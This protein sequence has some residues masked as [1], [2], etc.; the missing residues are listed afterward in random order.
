MS[1]V[2]LK[3]IVSPPLSR[4]HHI[5]FAYFG[6]EVVNWDVVKEHV[7]K[8]KPFVLHFDSHDVFNNIQVAKYTTETTAENEIRENMLV[9]LGSGIV[10]Q[11]RMTWSPHVSYEMFYE[12][13][14][15]FRVLGVESND[16]QFHYM[17]QM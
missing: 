4:T 5:T 11:N 8:L 14:S 3:L 6:K 7:S 16:G 15:I 10:S 17:F 13:P 12:P 1:K 9:M 2:Y